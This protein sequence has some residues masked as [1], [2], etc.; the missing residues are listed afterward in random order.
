MKRTLLLVLTTTI[1]AVLLYGCSGGEQNAEVPEEDALAASVGDW[2]ITKTYLY[3]YIAQLPESQR[4][5][6]DTHQGRADAADKFIQEELFYREALEEDVE[7][8]D[9]VQK[10]LEDA[11]RRILIGA[12]YREHVEA[13]ARPAEQDVHD[14]YESHQDVYTSL[15]IAR[16][17][18]IFSKSREK[19]E[20]LK[21]RILVGG[22]K[23]T[24]M[25]HRYSEDK[26][27]QRDGGDL[28]YFNP[29][30]YVRGIGYDPEF[31]DSLFMME[32]GKVYGPLKWN[33]G[34]SLVRINEKRPAELRP[35]ADVREEI[36]RILIEQRIDEARFDVTE[37]IKKKYETHNYMRDI[38]HSIQRSP[39]ELF[40][41]A[42]EAT[43]AQEK[44]RSYQE[45]VDKFPDD[46]TTPKAMFM[47]GFVYAEELTD[48][49]AADKTFARLIDRYPD[50]DMADQAQWM[51]DNL[52]KETPSFEEIQDRI[53]DSN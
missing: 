12:Y 11:R 7:G 45:I 43:S 29:G 34:W 46:P 32:L 33:R 3:D 47:I 24:T 35:Y 50:T 9:Y 28:G 38:F 8:L 15:E 31:S 13:Q 5:K 20:D 30:G 23:F 51:L 19:L 16:G 48:I 49:P 18:H 41:Y 53:D 17:Q 36:E 21:E 27:T 1:V 40:A 4:R 14:Y 37:Q 42:Q 25:A 22:E 6:Y 10:Q 44:I 52:G 2:T 26:I 39:E